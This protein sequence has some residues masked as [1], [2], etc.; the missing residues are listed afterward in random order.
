MDFEYDQVIERKIK[1][2]QVII[3]YSQLLHNIY[4]TLC[5]IEIWH[6]I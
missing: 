5:F 6:Y 1:K 3:L 2:K 4:D